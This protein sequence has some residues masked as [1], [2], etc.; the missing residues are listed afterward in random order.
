MLLLGTA[1]GSTLIAV[2]ASP[3]FA[4]NCTQPASPSPITVTGA[5]T[6][7]AC[8]N[9]DPRTA[10]VA[11]DNAIGIV[12]TG[13]GNTVDITNSGLLTT[14]ST[15]LIPG[16][17]FAQ[18][19]GARG[20]YA[21]TNGIGADITIN[22]TGTINSYSDS[23]KAV[24]A[25]TS[26]TVFSSDTHITITNSGA[27]NAGPNAEGIFANASYGSNN[28]VTIN[29]SG[30]I[31]TGA[32]ASL[33]GTSSGIFADV[34]GANSKIDVTNSAT[35][36][37]YGASAAGISAI[38]SY[39]HGD[40]SSI[41][42]NNK[43]AG[44]ITTTGASAY[45]IFAQA[46]SINPNN[47][48][49]N[50]DNGGTVKITNAA[51]VNAGYTGVAAFTYG[52]GGNITIDNKGN[53]TSGT[54]GADGS[55]GIKASANSGNSTITVT[56]TGNIDT[57]SGGDK[58]VG[59]EAVNGPG[60]AGSNLAIS[61][62][63]SGNITTGAESAG[64]KAA[65]TGDNGSV[66]VDNSG[67]IQTGASVST[68]GGSTGIFAD[69]DGDNTKVSVTNSGAISTIGTSAAGISAI[70]NY[71]HGNNGSVVVN[72]KAGG[73]ITTTGNEAYGIFAQAGSINPTNSPPN[74]DNGGTV[75]ITN[76]ATI[77]AGYMGVAGF[78][79]GTGGNITIDNKGNITSG[80]GGAGG[81]N[82]INAVVNDSN[83]TI[84]IT[85]TGDIDTTA[86]G[87]KSAGIHAVGGSALTTS[88]IKISIT[89]SGDIETAQNSVGIFGNAGGLNAA[90]TIEN[91]G[92]IETG[93][94]TSTSGGS[95]G[96]FA[97]V[98]G[99]NGQVNVTN[100]GAIFTTGTSAAGISTIANYYNGDNGSIVINNKA[101][102]TI[103]TTGVNA[104]G[105]FASA[106]SSDPVGTGPNRDDNGT[107]KITNAATIS[108]GYMGINADTYGNGGNITIDNKGN[109]T[110][111]T[112]GAGVSDGIKA[113][114]HGNDTTISVTNSGNIDTTA[115]GLKSVGIQA[116]GGSA[117]ANSNVHISVTNSG[118]IKTATNSVGIF[119]NAGGDNASTTV[120]NSGRIETGASASDSGGSSGIFADVDGNNSQVNVTNNGAI[121]TVGLTA[122]GISAIANYY[123]GTNGDIIIN[124]KAGGTITTT[125]AQ[126][127]GI[128]ASSGSSDPV[129]V[130][131]NT[132]DNGTIDITNAARINAGGFGI[133]ATSYGA[134][135]TITI[136]NNGDVFGMIGG[137]MV[138]SVA[139]ATINVGTSGYV[140]ADN[141]LAIKST[142]GTAEINDNGIIAGRVELSDADNVMNIND[143]GMFRAFTDSK[144]GAGNDTL[145]NSGIVNAS[146][147]YFGS[148]PNTV[149]LTGLENFVNGSLGSG[150][151]LTTMI[152]GVVGDQLTTSGNFTGRGN[153][154]LGVDTNFS[155]NSSD[156][157]TI[158]GNSYGHTNLV[159]N[160]TAIA[161]GVPTTTFIPVVTVTGTTSDSNF[162]VAAPVNAGLFAYDLFL[163]GKTHGLRYVGLGNAAFELPAGITGAQD[164]WEDTTGFWQDRMADLRSDATGTH[165]ADMP[166]EHLA[167]RM[168]GVWARA[169]GDWSS[170]DA[171]TSYTDPISQQTETLNLD[172]RQRTGAFLGG[173]DMGLEG[174]AGGDVLF[175]VMAGY[176]TSTLDFTATDDSWNYKGGTVGAYATYINGGFYLD[177]LVKADFLNVDIN[178]NQGAI[179]DKASTNA[180]NI[181]VRLDTGYR[182][183]MGWGFIEPQ[184]SLQ[185]VHTNMDSVSLFGGAIDFQ[186]GSSGRA[187]IGVRVGTDMQMNGMTV[188]PDLTLSVWNHF[189]SSN[190]VNIDFPGNAFSAT[191][192]AGNGTFGEVGVGVNVA[193][194]SNWSGVVRGSVRFGDHYSAGSIGAAIRYG[195]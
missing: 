139:G 60:F 116:V 178:D 71:Y 38:A 12:T 165:N 72:N 82:G 24:S 160:V 188:T 21:G 171:S 54:G 150:P 31:Q 16:P 163:Q 100:S 3:S 152:D 119:V 122:A 91:S 28:A 146:G 185:W 94:S 184:A 120:N 192:S 191:D 141:Y 177:G 166:E 162:D 85:N 87:L 22:N 77:S 168:G 86:G 53:I 172:R 182:I 105:I 148:T 37:T 88:N 20:I 52:S 40:N 79:Y 114:I 8:T 127:Y 174:V 109:I 45:G 43:A 193:S 128:F 4:A 97:D 64:I 147:S 90:V 112:G 145:N 134:S 67:A 144:F 102:G 75:K 187:K 36:S 84:S 25:A 14:N 33:S 115:G 55:D 68:I 47:S 173:I 131:P 76:A 108:A 104:Y 65:S 158:G 186:N 15:S 59:I 140:G 44:T 78:T 5:T 56:N 159:V 99:E 129:G 125:G 9:T 133:G 27:L 29:N 169:M 101:G 73:T 154:K 50:P 149:T 57:T 7:I 156:T 23:I 11:G 124:N 18:S 118:D 135:S 2:S 161:P 157:L 34:D 63:N 69:A 107:I 41:V 74:P 126:A 83:S 151:G 19:K 42:I 113:L 130:G 179:S 132:N 70:A 106:G 190:S 167:A 170:R 92:R 143:K 80:T 6:P 93:A 110:S 66:T 195:W 98:D 39:Y 181:G 189:G 194:A 137:I 49:P 96:I 164:V 175:G 176:V 155:N 95:S 1:L 153:S 48:P 35:I 32:S 136:T 46:G 81:S 13:N 89:N 26:G 58:S 62:T 61:V 142:A 10:T 17:S 123:N 138:S 30:A 103:T 51:T 121:K 111:G 183:G 117:L 180:T